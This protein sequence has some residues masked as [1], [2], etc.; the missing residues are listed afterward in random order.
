MQ[1][2]DTG[3]YLGMITVDATYTPSFESCNGNFRTAREKCADAYEVPKDD[4]G[5]QWEY[6]LGGTKYFNK[7]PKNRVY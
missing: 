7:W 4:I 1:R 6:W 2:R 3:E 5:M